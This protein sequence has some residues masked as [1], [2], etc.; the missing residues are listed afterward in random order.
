MSFSTLNLGHGLTLRRKPKMVN[1]GTAELEQNTTE[2][3]THTHRLAK[4]STC[5]LIRLQKML[6]RLWIYLNSFWDGTWA[7]WMHR[8]GTSAGMIKNMVQSQLYH[9]WAVYLWVSYLT[10]SRLQLP[11]M[12]PDASTTC[13]SK[14]A[15]KIRDIGNA[16]D[17]VLDTQLAFN[18]WCM[19]S[20]QLC[21]DS[22]GPHKL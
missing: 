5:N 1:Q 22:L 4:T 12:L 2:P 21:P 8:V 18:A 11:Q 3:H 20:P 15:E 16:F 17:R 9:L 14:V 19:M 7:N 10:S 6:G 13:A